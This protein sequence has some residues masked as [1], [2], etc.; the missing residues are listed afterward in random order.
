MGRAQNHLLFDIY[1]W[2]F[3][4]RSY[5][6]RENAG[7]RR[8]NRF[9]SSQWEEKCRIA[10]QKCSELDG[11]KIPETEKWWH[12]K[13]LLAELVR[14]ERRKKP[15]PQKTSAQPVVESHP[16]RERR[17][18]DFYSPE[19]MEKCKIINEKCAEIEKLKISPT[20]KLWRTKQNAR[21]S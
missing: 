2:L 1:K 17:K 12:V 7:T 9:F 20:E 4:N 3:G 18:L 15:R 6:G 13:Q 8:F 16:L 19:W 11:K 14:P 21:P 5:G 10:L